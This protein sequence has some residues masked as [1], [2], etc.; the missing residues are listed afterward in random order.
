MIKKGKRSGL[1]RYLCK[2]CNRFYSHSWREKE[3]LKKKIWIDYVF[4]KQTLRELVKIYELD[5]KT[6]CKYLM[7]Y[8]PKQKVHTPRPVRLL[9]DALYFG[10]R[11][12]K[13]TWCVIVFRDSLTKENLWWEF[14]DT[15]RE[16]VYLRGRRELEKLGYEILSVTGDGLPLI[17]SAFRG[18]PFQMCLVHME[19]IIIRGTTRKPKLEAGKVLFA[20]STVIHTVSPNDFKN[21]LNKFTIK[22]F[23]FLNEKTFNE[24]T[25]ERWFTHEE[26]RRAFVTLQNL[27]PYL[28]TYITDKDIPKTTNSLEGHFAHLRDIVNIHRGSSKLLKQKVIQTILL[29][30]TI[31]PNEKTEQEVV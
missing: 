14:T 26:L 3:G 19:R 31:A 15:E 13:T 21:Y 12:E 30:S 10:S 1:I 23:S 11:L 22:Y 25:G 24:T 6:I 4:N 18:I 8:I 28:F 20:L 2:D 16:S 7:E 9:V 27:H 17:R 29:A 5:R